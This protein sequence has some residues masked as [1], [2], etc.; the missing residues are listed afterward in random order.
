M[1]LLFFSTFV[2]VVLSACSNSVSVRLSPSQGFVRLQ[3][4]E[5]ILKRDL[6]VPAGHARVFVQE[7][8][9]VIGG[10]DRYLAHCALEVQRVDHGGFTIKAGNFRVVRVQGSMQQVV[11]AGPV[12]LASLQLVGGIGAAG[13]STYHQ[14]YHFWL[15]SEEQPEVR[16]MSCYGVYADPPDLEPPSLQE[17][18]AV[19]GDIAEIRP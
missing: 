2:A 17:I 13:S 12:M 7:G 15:D 4:A 11:M 8:R 3:G 9:P 10:L 1:R 14:G 5:L 16:R 6:T 19:L 18:G